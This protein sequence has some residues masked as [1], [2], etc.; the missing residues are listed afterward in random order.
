MSG[1]GKVHAYLFSGRSSNDEKS[2]Y[3][4]ESTAP[5]DAKAVE[6]LQELLQAEYQS[7]PSLMVCVVGPR[8]ELVS[9]WS[10]NAC[11]IMHNVGIPQITR[12]ER[13]EVL[14]ED[15]SNPVDHMV[16]AVYPILTPTT[17][18]IDGLA[19][20][21][22]NIHDIEAF[23]LEAGLALS[24]QEIV[25]LKEVSNKLARPLTDAELFGFAQVN[26]EHCRHKIF[27]GTFIIDGQTQEHSLF[28]LIKLTAAQA[29]HNLVSAYKDNVAFLKGPKIMQFAPSAAH[30]PSWFELR[31]IESVIS[32]KAETHNFPTTVEPFSGAST[33]AGG[34]IRDRMAGG[35]GS[36]PLIGTA[37]YMTAY[38][39]LGNPRAHSYETL[40]PPRPWLYQTPA[41][42][43][44]KA[45]NG[46]SDFGNK[47]GQP[48]ITGSLLTFEMPTNRALYAYDRC[49]MLAGGVGYATAS[50]SQKLSVRP[51]DKIVLLGGDNY[52][53]GLA[54]G[55]VSSVGSGEYAPQLELNA[56]QRA[57]PEMQKRVYNVIRAL[58][59]QAS[60]P[61]RSIH[62]HGAGGHMNCFTEL[63]DPQGGHIYLER[64]PIGDKTLSP[65]EIICNESQER[66]GL[67][68]DAKDLKLL[69]ESCKRERAP[70][71][72]VGEIT[73]GGAI[74][75]EDKNG[76]RPVDLP[77]N[78]LLGNSPPIV[79][80]DRNVEL[81]KSPLSFTPRNGDQL[82]EVLEQV[83]S[84][85]G[86]AC[87]DWLT[88]KVDRS[89][90]GKVA[91]QQC[92]GPLQLPLADAGV[93][94]LDYCSKSGIATAIGHAPA[95]GIVDERAGSI[96]SLAEA[97]TNLVWAPL[98][99]GLRSIALSANWMWPCKRAGEDA[100]LYRAV[101]ALSKAACELGIPV[102]TGKDSLS[103]TVRYPDG[104]EVR[105]PGTVII[106]AVGEV[107]DVQKCVTPD[108]K[109]ILNS[110]L[111]YINLSSLSTN[112][113]GGSALAQVLGKTGDC[114]PTIADYPLFKAGFNAIQTL[115]GQ[116]FILAGHDVSAG[117]VITTLCEMAFA[118]NIGIEIDAKALSEGD[119][120]PFLFTEK[121]ALV[122]QVARE[123]Q[124][125]VLNALQT[126][127]LSPL[128]LGAPLKS[129]NI[130]LKAGRLSFTR[131]LSELRRIWY[132]P[133]FLL[134]K[135][136][137]K[138]DKAEERY[139][140][141]EEQLLNYEF[142]SGFSG[143]L[144]DYG[145]DLMRQK[146]TNLTAAIVREQGTNGDREMAF[147]L[148]AA[149]F[150]VKDITMTDL[151]SG[152]ETL[153]QIKFVVF[154]GGFANSDVLGAGRGWGAAFMYNERAIKILTKFMQ[155]E[156]TLSL[157]VCN[158]C[159]L[160]VT[161]NLLYP[162]HSRKMEMRPNDSGK[163]ESAF[164]NVEIQPTKSVLLRD[165]AGARLGIW[166]A[167][168][169][170]KFHLPEDEK[171][172]DI[173]VRFCKASYPANPNGSDFNAAAVC[174]Q[175]GRHLAIMPH[176]E[177]SIFPWQWPYYPALKT[178]Q[179]TPWIVAFTSAREWIKERT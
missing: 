96:M 55:S 89:V 12:M 149:G 174:S 128:L 54:G 102:P 156:D 107:S 106:S 92:V 85:E 67:V 28:S 146:R 14:R 40:T 37:V 84:L 140:T 115:L 98:K 66:M 100:R 52:R 93:V 80:E 51:G 94:A 160:M 127:G 178:H 35:R 154:P 25:Y 135:L 18:I 82:L 129:H 45:S 60:N 36:I 70:C 22:R 87:K 59:E 74:V 169:E 153:D 58:C 118:G 2:F 10:T 120:M 73:A 121:P 41:Q 164:I 75:F 172:Y 157:G 148:F 134:D 167:H 39:R 171:S 176:L 20:E 108:L 124:A 32:L 53:I 72:V 144:L 49:V 110:H 69:E 13:F 113:L 123:H 1:I 179:V 158:G 47:F 141:F 26:S 48:L 77:L 4:V 116:G 34:E 61:I 7:A 3:I 138:K 119:L 126:A 132:Y 33:G 142:P 64:L 78:L 57:N 62:D 165:L 131:S 122:I 29:G 95:V 145:V 88:N 173:P 177:R 81:E 43:L 133:S 8:K 137:T 175:D 86:V 152:R 109:P 44:V 23:N 46:A 139:R 166:V 105:A 5:L 130:T 90:T 117:G 99:E 91:L 168:G 16:Q 15:T 27:N 147:S 104:K 155:R 56:V 50:Q 6:V 170:G 76:N 17:L 150:D 79:V 143:K 125:T 11:D 161:L 24:P 19:E 151:L 136:Q 30:V 111:F 63:V 103:M 31:E 83:L 21:P 101:Q 163:F 9:P 97:L 71:Y 38:P 68:M 162:Q 159:Q 65:R 42:I 112:P 114:V